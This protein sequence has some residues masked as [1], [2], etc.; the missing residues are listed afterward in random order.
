MLDQIIV[1]VFLDGEETNVKILIVLVIVQVTELVQ[2]QISVNVING[3]KEIV[4]K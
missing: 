1:I 3:G 4:V 2:D